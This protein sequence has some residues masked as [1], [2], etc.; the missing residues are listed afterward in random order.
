MYPVPKLNHEDSDSEY[1]PDDFEGT[2]TSL[3]RKL[4]WNMEQ[5]KKLKDF[6]FPEIFQHPKSENLPPLK[7]KV[8]KN[9]DE[10]DREECEALKILFLKNDM[11]V[12]GK[13]SKLRGCNL[14]SI[15]EV[16]NEYANNVSQKS[17]FKLSTV[18]G[19]KCISY[20]AGY[21]YPLD[22]NI[23]NIL[24]LTTEHT[25]SIYNARD[26]RSSN[27]LNFHALSNSINSLSCHSMKID[28]LSLNVPL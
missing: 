4:E 25:P 13:L 23:D 21:F 1:E 26:I 6:K 15:E 19:F 12:L 27:S 18:D 3:K 20:R 16:Y 10:E 28:Y 9:T 2:A 22:T 11:S 24:S 17:D 14:E 7:K 8:I 5:L